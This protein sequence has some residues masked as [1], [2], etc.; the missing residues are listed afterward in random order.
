MVAPSFFERSVRSAE[1]HMW[2]PDPDFTTTAALVRAI[3]KAAPECL[4]EREQAAWG[5]IFGTP[6]AIGYHILD[7]GWDIYDDPSQDVQ[8]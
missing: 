7:H 2:R 8:P 4:D 6:Y 3:F 5:A 1:R